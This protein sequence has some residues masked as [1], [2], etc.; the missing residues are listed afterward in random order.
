MT[1]FPMYTSTYSPAYSPWERRRDALDRALAFWQQKE[2]ITD[3]I[4]AEDIIETAE[5]FDAFIAPRP[6]AEQA[7]G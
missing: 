2:A 5:V 1:N 6:A 7:S 3:V 4:S